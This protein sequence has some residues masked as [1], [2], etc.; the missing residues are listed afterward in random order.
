M[1]HTVNALIAM[2]RPVADDM[3][4][5]LAEK[6]A[7]EM[8]AVEGMTYQDIYYKLE[9]MEHLLSSKASVLEKAQ[10]CLKDIAFHQLQD[11][12]PVIREAHVS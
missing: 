7:T 12:T 11:Q 4:K 8:A 3:M 2:E 10:W 6:I 5:V 1:T 9:D